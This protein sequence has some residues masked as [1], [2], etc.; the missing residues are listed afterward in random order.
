VNAT[1]I[2]GDLIAESRGNEAAAAYRAFK[3]SDADLA[4]LAEIG[5]ALLDIFPKDVPGACAVMSALYASQLEF[6]T[7]VPVFV[8]AGS[9]FV[10][11]TR[12]FGDDTKINGKER[13]SRSDSSWDGHVWLVM[14]HCIADA[15]IFRTAYSPRSPPIL[16]AHVLRKFGKGKGLLIDS[17]EAIGELGLSYVPE[18]VLTEDQIT[19]LALGGMAIIDNNSNRAP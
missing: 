1:E 19:G 12:V 10:G 3:A 13:L 9:L 5:R 7:R 18:Y 8:V 2:I 17:I 4:A 15:S 6:K 14:G 11:Q 16:A